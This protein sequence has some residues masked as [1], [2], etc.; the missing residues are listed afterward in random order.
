MFDEVALVATKLDDKGSEYVVGI[1]GDRQDR[2]SSVVV[3]V[4][5]EIQFQ[6]ELAAAIASYMALKT[7][8][9]LRP[10]MKGPLM[11][12]DRMDAWVVVEGYGRLT[13]EE[14][15]KFTR[16]LRYYPRLTWWVDGEKVKS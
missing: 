3:P 6:P 7:W 2:E 14:R 13:V 12:I 8:S 15:K 16:S 5:S 1:G 4:V 11:L 9:D 10:G